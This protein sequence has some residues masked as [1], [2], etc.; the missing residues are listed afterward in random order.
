MKTKNTMKIEC[1]LFLSK[2]EEL[3][4]LNDFSNQ[5]YL[6]GLVGITECYFLFT[7]ETD[8]IIYKFS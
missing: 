8:L 2:I 6:W 3:Q 4:K 1:R 7:F 5:N